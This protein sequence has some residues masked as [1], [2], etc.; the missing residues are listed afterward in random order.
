MDRIYL[1]TTIEHLEHERAIH[2][3]KYS[4]NPVHANCL[5]NFDAAIEKLKRELAK[6]DGESSHNQ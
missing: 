4:G 2:D 3:E 6:L 1:K 5:P